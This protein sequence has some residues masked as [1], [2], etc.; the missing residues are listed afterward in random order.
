MTPSLTIRAP[1]RR[2]RIVFN[3]PTREKRLALTFDDGPS[4]WTTAILAHLGAHGA[5]ATF[6][7]LGSSIPGREN[8]LRRIAAEGH[9]LGN[10]TYSHPE[11]A[12][13][14]GRRVREELRRTTEL[15]QRTAR[16]RPRLFR[17]PYAAADRRVALLA[18]SVGLSP[19]VLRSVDPADWSG[20]SAGEIVAT[21]L[22]GAGPG[23]IVC[24]HDGVSPN[25]SGSPSRQPTVDAVAELV[26]TLVAQGFELV[27]V[28]ELLE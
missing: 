28:S 6:F 15:I 14:D 16:V 7:V 3:V 25:R 8:V 10:H 22:E 13:L 20:T 11:L 1:W 9:E 24:L 21:V 26:P 19:T 12:E 27:T 17:P 4:E 18:A 23:E 2:P 5:R